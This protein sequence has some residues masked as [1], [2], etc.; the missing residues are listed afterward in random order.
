MLPV[1]GKC[2]TLWISL[3]LQKGLLF[4]KSYSVPQQLYGVCTSKERETWAWRLE[5]SLPSVHRTRE[6]DVPVDPF[7]KRTQY[8]DVWKIVLLEKCNLNKLKVCH[9]RAES[10]SSIV[11]YHLRVILLVLQTLFATKLVFNSFAR[12][13][14]NCAHF[15]KNWKKKK[16]PFN[17]KSTSKT[18]FVDVYRTYTSLTAKVEV[19]PLSGITLKPS[20]PSPTTIV[21]FR[22]IFFIA[23]TSN[24]EKRTKSPVSHQKSWGIL[25]I[26][27]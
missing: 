18:C 15:S 16:A 14:S 20:N 7:L 10:I 25:K 9:W 13:C 12:V 22:R 5:I 26:L 19:T 4:E 3:R 8:E 11:K 2:P 27:V 1:W 21:H 6:V 23:S 17:D 24:M